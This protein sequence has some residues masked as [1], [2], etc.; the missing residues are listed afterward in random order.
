MVKAVQRYEDDQ[1]LQEY[2]LE[3]KSNEPGPKPQ[4]ARSESR[5]KTPLSGEKARI[6]NG[7]QYKV[8]K[9]SHSTQQSNGK[10]VPKYQYT[11]TKATFGSR[12]PPQNSTK[13]D[14]YSIGNLAN[15][16]HSFTTLQR[17]LATQQSLIDQLIVQ[18]TSI[19]SQPA[20]PPP[21]PPTQ[22]SSTKPTFKE[23]TGFKGKPEHVDPFWDL[24]KDA[25]DLQASALPTPRHRSIYA[26]GYFGDAGRIWYRGVKRSNS[27]L[28]DDFDGFKQAFRDHFGDKNLAYNLKLKIRALH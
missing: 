14:D 3:G 20:A 15:I 13:P 21:P 4:P 10:F 25:I 8:V 17:T 22:L 2:Y 7:A 18:V 5:P 24:V 27:S 26:A 28:L 6:V 9:K 11:S 16:Q 12:A 23:P 19:N 1:A